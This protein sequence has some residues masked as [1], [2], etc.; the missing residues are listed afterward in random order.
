MVER[1]GRLREKQAS[2]AIAK[3]VVIL[4]EIWV[5]MICDTSN[6]RY[7]DI[8]TASWNL[9]QMKTNSIW[10][11]NTTFSMWGQYSIQ[12]GSRFDCDRLNV[13]DGSRETLV[14]YL[15]THNI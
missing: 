2:D 5:M 4:T 12:S 7:C 3:Q 14:Q 10:I 13:G 11:L 1:L 9:I 6:E 8:Y 15:S